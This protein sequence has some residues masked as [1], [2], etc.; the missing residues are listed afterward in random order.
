MKSQGT[1]AIWTLLTREDT[2]STS[3]HYTKPLGLGC[4]LCGKISISK[5]TKDYVCGTGAKWGL[6]KYLQSCDISFTSEICTSS[7][8]L[9]SPRLPSLSSAGTTEE[10]CLTD[11]YHLITYTH[12]LT[13]LSPK[14]PQP[15]TTGQQPPAA[16]PAAHVTPVGLPHPCP[17]PQGP[18]SPPFPHTLARRK[19]GSTEP[20][21]SSLETHQTPL[22][23]VRI[24]APPALPLPCRSCTPSQGSTALTLPPGRKPRP[25]RLSGRRRGDSASPRQ[26]P[27]P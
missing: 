13:T 14:L 9:L 5:M 17:S 4:N 25:G 1:Y 21:N 8:H 6:K 2:L 7:P 16:A 27:S 12:T 19:K 11:L 26:T 23:H 10:V 18:P 22:Y 3:Q 24:P 20:G 15:D